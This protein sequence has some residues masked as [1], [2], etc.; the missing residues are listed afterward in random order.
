MMKK[1]KELRT[2]YLNSRGIGEDF[3]EWFLKRKA[4]DKTKIVFAYALW[5]FWILFWFK[6]HWFIFL[7]EGLALACVLYGAYSVIKKLRNKS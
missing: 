7:L 5:G 4:S 2:D 6:P 1:I 3:L